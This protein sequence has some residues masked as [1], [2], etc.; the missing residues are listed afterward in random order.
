MGLKE[1]GGQARRETE[2]NRYKERHRV[3]QTLRDRI[4]GPFLQEMQDIDKRQKHR[5]RPG[6]QD[7]KHSY[8]CREQ[9]QRQ[10]RGP[11]TDRMTWRASR[12]EGAG[13]ETW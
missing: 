12:T 2:P 5:N 3:R 9:R 8:S 1:P 10:R 6:H 7:P 4:E 11:V 13:R